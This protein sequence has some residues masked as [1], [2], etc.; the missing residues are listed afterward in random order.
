MAFE[1][2]PF[3]NL[4]DGE[5]KTITLDKLPSRATKTKAGKTMWVYEITDEAR[6]RASWWT[7]PEVHTM[8]DG[9]RAGD[10]IMVE[11][12]GKDWSIEPISP[13]TAPG[14]SSPPTERDQRQPAK[15]SYTVAELAALMR[16]CQ[17]S[18]K[19]LIEN[20]TSEMVTSL[21]ISA[22]REGIRP[23]IERKA[24]EPEG[25]AF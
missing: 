8:L 4:E 15:S 18:A 25:E 10:Q 14:R 3:W 22:Q 24:V 5:T 13:R 7:W 12:V 2:L 20:P 17:V 21:F 9:L 23:V 19:A 11:H 1:R 6:K 16:D